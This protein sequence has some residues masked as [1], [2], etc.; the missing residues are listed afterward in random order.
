MITHGTDT[1]VDTAAALNDAAPGKTIVLVGA[2]TPA[3]FTHSEAVFN[4]GMAFAAAQLAPPG[5]HVAMNG[6]IFPAAA[7]RKDRSPGRFV[8]A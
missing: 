2:L 6:S 3:R 4:L 5:C 1:I 8:T 7:V